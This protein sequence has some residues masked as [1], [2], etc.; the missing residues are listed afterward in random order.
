MRRIVIPLIFGLAGTAVLIGLGIWQLQR[1]AWKE[2]VLADIDA[3][4]AAAP[5]ALPETPE[6]GA[7]RYLP[8]EVTGTIGGAPLRVLVS[9]KGVGAGYRLIVPLDTGARRVMADLGFVRADA[10][11]PDLPEEPVTVTGNLH[12]PDDRTSSIP[13][14]DVAGNIWFARDIAQMAGVLG[15]EPILVVVRNMSE[16]VPGLTPMPVD[17]SAIPNDHLGYAVTW[18]SL[19]VIWLIMTGY[20]LVRTTRAQKGSQT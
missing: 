9:R 19:A 6:P 20:F 13:D 3:R 5:L 8:V 11:L 15:T 12:W 4:I 17:S 14:N 18:F 7:D 1:L 10:A 2:A 16:S